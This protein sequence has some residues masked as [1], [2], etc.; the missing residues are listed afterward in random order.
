MYYVDGHSRFVLDVG[1]YLPDY[2]PQRT[3][4]LIVTAE[5][6]LNPIYDSHSISAKL[7]E[8]PLWSI[9]F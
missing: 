5:R 8:S 4:T 6:N 9:V 2:S 1:T 7:L 3:V